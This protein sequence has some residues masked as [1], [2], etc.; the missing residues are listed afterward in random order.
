MN[1]SKPT[2]NNY[3]HGYNELATP[4]DAFAQ[5][6]E[7]QLAQTIW[8]RGD[9]EVRMSEDLA[10]YHGQYDEATQARIDGKKT[11]KSTAFI[12]LTRYKSN[13]AEAQLVDLLFPNDDKNWGINPTPS[14]EIDKDL[15]DDSP[16]QVGEQQFK[17]EEGQV[18][19]IADLA[20]NQVELVKK[21]CEAMELEIN[22]QLIETDY[23]KKSRKAIHDAVTVGTG[24]LKGATVTNKSKVSYQKKR[25]ANNFE[26]MSVSSFNPG[27]SVVRPWDF[28]P[29]MSASDIEDCEFVYERS[30]MNSRQVRNLINMGYFPDQ[31]A[32]LL[33]MTAKT[34]QHVSSN[35]DDIRRLSGVRDQINDNRYEIWEYHGNLPKDVL[36][37]LEK[38][39]PEEYEDP[40]QQYFGVAI[41]SGGI[42][43]QV[44]MSLL[45]IPDLSVYHVFNWEVDEGSL[46]G[47]GVPR[48]SK[49]SQRHINTTWRMML[50][51]ASVT[52]GGQ[53]GIK[54]KHITPANGSYEITANK[55][56]YVGNG[57]QDIK[58][59]MSSFEFNSHL[60][61]LGDLYQLARTFMD[62]ETGVPMINQGEQGQATQ[63]L[64]GMS[65][66]MNAANA[67]RRRQV[68]EWDDKITDPLISNFYHFNMK[69]SDKEEIKGD[70][71]VDARGTSALLAKEVQGQAILNLISVASNSPVFSPMLQV[72]AREVYEAWCKTQNLPKEL[73]PTKEEFDQFIQ[74]QA[75]QAQEQGEQGG[76]QLEVEQFKAQAAQKLEQLRIQGDIAIAQKANEVK[77]LQLKVDLER[78]MR[79]ERMEIMK[80]EEAG[81]LKDGEMESKLKAIE[82]KETVGLHKFNAEIAIKHQFNSESGNDGLDQH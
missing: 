48:M 28:F 7:A 9:I 38:I 81:R 18:I 39:T 19:K 52:V 64:G 14:P 63:T 35:A 22:D 27:V 40:L 30:Y 31:V 23:N 74:D 25:N 49:E 4:L 67:V 1:P 11:G 79:G 75:A 8:E 34:T 20:A 76:G 13:S 29:D 69:Y 50:D 71:Q 65:M 36:L 44:R 70:Y 2:P 17:D 45:D 42:C 73:I 5:A 21:A 80:L 61:E 55:L 47:F 53:L 59:A 26:L 6:L 32:R 10:Q 46:F 56:W 57:I 72:K 82:I 24:I 58:Q 15:N 62:E 41:F 3:Q 33:K 68:K 78:S 51:N 16:V 60:Q 77:V 54:Q 43:L 37:Q 66:L 12:N